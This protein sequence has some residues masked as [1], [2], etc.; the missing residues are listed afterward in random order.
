[1]CAL[2]PRTNTSSG[3]I[4]AIACSSEKIHLRGEAT[5]AI[6]KACHDEKGPSSTTTPRPVNMNIGIQH[7]ASGPF[8][9]TPPFLVLEVFPSLPSLC[10]KFSE[11]ALPTPLS[12]RVLVWTQPRPRPVFPSPAIQP[13]TYEHGLERAS[14]SICLPGQRTLAFSRELYAR[15]DHSHLTAHYA[16]S[17]KRS[18]VDQLSKEAGSP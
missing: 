7:G 9:R 5:G 12:S 16:I 14:A 6:K 11:H 18:T 2:R 8:I 10:N 3:T 1:M 13:A 17:C 15:P 4:R